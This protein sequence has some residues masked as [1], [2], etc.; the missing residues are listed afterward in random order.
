MRPRL[1]GGRVLL[2]GLLVMALPSVIAASKPKG[3]L[4][5]EDV[6]RMVMTGT[7]EKDILAAIESRPA[8]FDLTTD[9]VDELRRAGVDDTIIVAM[10]RRQAAMPQP[11]PSPTPVPEAGRSGTLRVEFADGSDTASPAERSAIA[12]K[13][14]PKGMSRHGGVEVGLMTDMALVVLCI[15][16]DHVP[17]H[18]DTRSPIQGAPR[19]ELLLFRPGSGTDKLKGHEVLYLDHEASYEVPVP[20]GDHNIVVGA[21]GK[22]AG[23]GTWRL[24]E[25][26][27]ARVAIVPGRT[28]RVTL[29]A[30]SAIK[31]SAMIG[32][33]VD[34]RWKI[35]GVE[36]LEETPGPG[37][38]T[39][40]PAGGPR[41]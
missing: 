4:T 25:S 40:T 39:P 24:L 9:M 21:A 18:W 31:G 28:T 19:H 32:F 35:V 34:T 30:R 7:A 26:D 13:S 12:L 27:G 36:V 15:S 16:A 8:D 11:E 20:E 3:P 17:D 33:N 1:P 37:S 2:L 23:S 5:N 6:V 38:P 29:E 22:Q 10:R 41:R 14:L